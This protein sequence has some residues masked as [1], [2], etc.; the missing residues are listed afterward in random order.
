MWT[1][2]F[3]WGYETLTSQGA[4]YKEI[5][6][7]TRS[8]H[9]SRP[10]KK[11][12]VGAPSAVSSVRRPASGQPFR[13]EKLVLPAIKE[14]I[15]TVME[16]DPT[17]VLKSI[18]L[19]NDTVAQRIN[20]MGTDTE[21]QLCAILQNPPF[22]LQLERPLTTMLCWWPMFAIGPQTIR[23]W[24]RNFCFLNICIQ[25]RARG[26]YNALNVFLQEKSILITNMV[27]RYHDL[28]SLLKDVMW[29]HVPCRDFWKDW[30]GPRE[31]WC[32]HLGGGW[33]SPFRRTWLNASLP[34]RIYWILLDSDDEAPAV[35]STCGWG[36]M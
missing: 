1:S 5:P 8:I 11:S 18:P 2:A 19:N 32:S 16:H 3:K 25:T 4:S 17:Q 7:Q 27:G 36:S 14:V 28:T 29:H 26:I 22:G 23:R 10:S 34:S 13:E 20:E 31:P 21:E 33:Y 30:H 9:F 6:R 15:S 12:L 35:F 24:L